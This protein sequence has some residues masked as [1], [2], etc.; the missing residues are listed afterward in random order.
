[1]SLLRTLGMRGI[2]RP[3]AVGLLAV[4]AVEFTASVYARTTEE[5]WEDQPV[6]EASTSATATP[7]SA[8]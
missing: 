8:E 1:M 4:C 3:I 7:G 6:Q 5:L 2:P